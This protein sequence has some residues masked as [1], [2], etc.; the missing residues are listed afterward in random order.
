MRAMILI[1]V[2]AHSN[3]PEVIP[4]TTTSAA[5]TI[6]E[7]R[8]VFP[9]HGLPEQ[10]VSDDGTQF[11]ADEFRAFVRSNGMKHTKS[12]PFHPTTNGMAERFVQTFKKA[13]RAALT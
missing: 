4:L 12:A 3:W 2:D 6:E 8:K 13:L 9:T 10:L 5:R 1:V 7:L 11:T